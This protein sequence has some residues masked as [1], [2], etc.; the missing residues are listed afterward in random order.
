MKSKIQFY[1]GI[2]IIV[3]SS[4]VSDEIASTGSI[5][6]IVKDGSTAQPLQGCLITLSPSGKTISTGSDGLYSFNDLSPDQYSLEVRKEGY[7][8]EKKETT[9][10]AGSANKVDIFLSKE[11]EGLSITP[12]VLNFGDLE[13]S[14]ELFISNLTGTGSISYTIKA[15]ADWISLSSEEGT[16]SSTA[17][18]IKVVVDRSKLSIGDY[19]KVLKIT[20]P[21]GEDNIPVIVKQVEKSTAKIGMGDFSD[22]TDTSFSIKGVIHGTGGLQITSHGH[23]WSESEL[24]TIEESS[25]TNLGDTREIGDFVSQITQLT[26]G[27]TYYVRAYAIN[28]KGISYSEQTY[29]TIPL[30]TIPTVKTDPATNIKRSEATLNGVIIDKGGS[31]EIIECGFY[32]GTTTEPTIKLICENSSTTMF[33]HTLNSLSPETTY[34]YKAYA[35]NEKDISYGEVVSFVTNSDETEPW[36]GSVASSFGGGTGSFIDPYLIK[37]GSQLAL[38]RSY[39][40]AYFKLV[41]NVD[42]NDKAWNPITSFSGNFDGNGKTI[43]NLRINRS[44]DEIGLFGHIRSGQVSNLTINRINIDGISNSYVGGLV[45]YCKGD[46]ENCHIILN[47][48]LIKGNEYVGG[49]MGYGGYGCNINNCTVKA[50]TSEY[51]IQGNSYVGGLAGMFEGDDYAN[52]HETVLCTSSHSSV[53]ILGG[54]YIGGCFGYMGDCST[55]RN[56]SFFGNISGNSYAGGI[57]GTLKMDI[58]YYAANVTSCKVV[59]NI[60]VA[61]NYGG[62]LIGANLGYHKITSCY[63]SGEASSQSSS[64][65]LGGIVGYI[66]PYYGD[67]KT[68]IYNSYSTVTFSGTNISKGGIVGG[69][70]KNKARVYLYDCFTIDDTLGGTDKNNCNTNCTNDDIVNYLRDAGANNWNFSKTWTWKGLINGESQSAICPCLNWE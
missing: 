48:S 11:K 29:I 8:S 54:K 2:I 58:S 14:K 25:R 68:Y 34:Y 67:G 27:K 61:S 10:A 41:K 4:C 22:I 15:N 47:N 51:I 37:N 64:A 57:A 21:L 17:N 18:K 20:S 40:S 69:Y 49:I 3:L 19:E 39:S 12:E 50:N 5:A 55:I 62:G 45:G 33:N 9:I 1:L 7:K 53:N 56:S 63:A 38:V 43:S 70:N 26:A 59:G 66:A 32:Y 42:L 28:G 31:D 24:P 30:L 65:Y 44:Q 46:I 16:V 52:S 6:G 35:I 23:C 60:Q 13:T 36:D